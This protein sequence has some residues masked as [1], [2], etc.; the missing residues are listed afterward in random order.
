MAPEDLTVGEFSSSDFVIVESDASRDEALEKF[1][2]YEFKDKPSIYYIFVE[3][4]DK[5]EGVA[6][7]KDLMN[8]GTL[9]EAV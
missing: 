7:V 6:S 8:A 2:G 5:L 1:R 4:N 3:E 9:E